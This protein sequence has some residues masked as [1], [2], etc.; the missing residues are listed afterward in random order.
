MVGNPEDRFSHNEA[1]IMDRTVPYNDEAHLTLN[2][3]CIMV[4]AY[5]IKFDLFLFHLLLYANG[6]QLRSCRN[7][8]LF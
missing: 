4:Y 7:D 5:D 3:Q 2:M 8:Q 1:H 6:E